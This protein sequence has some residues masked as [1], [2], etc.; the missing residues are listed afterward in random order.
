MDSH[1]NNPSAA[2]SGP[3]S[4]DMRDP[5]Q[6]AL[7][8]TT[9]I[10][11]GCSNGAEPKAEMPAKVRGPAVAGLF[12]PLNDK[13]LAENIDELLAE[14][15]AAD[16]KNLRALVA[17][18]A[19]YKYSGPVAASAYKQLAGRR[20]ETVV[21]MSPSHFARF[22]GAYV[23]AVD[24]YETPLGRMR[25]SPKAAQL[26]KT[27]PF[28]AD[29]RC[30]MQRPD[31]WRQS[32]KE[33]PPFGEEAPD[34]WEHSL[35][36]QLPFI[37]RMLGEV[38]LIPITFGN[39][40]GADVARG[41]APLVDRQT[42]LVASSDLSHYHAYDDASQRDR[43]CVQA[44]C[45][46]SAEW[47][48]QQEAC[49]MG[50]ILTVV[51]LARRNG[52]K[53]R[54]LDCRNSGDTTGDKSR[55]VVGYAAIAFYEPEAPPGAAPSAPATAAAEK[56]KP[57]YSPEQ[58]KRLLALARESLVAATARHRPPEA[59]AADMDDALLA[60]R[61]CFVTLTKEGK[62]RGCVGS[63]FPQE[64]LYQ[65]VLHRAR[66]AAVEDRRFTPVQP[67]EVS[68]IKIEISVLT[69][70][71]PIEYKTPNELLD[72]LRPHV[73]GVVLRVGRSQ[74]T[75]LPQ[76]WEQIPGKEEFLQHLSQKAGLESGDWRDPKAVVL[77][78]QVEA[79]E[80][81]QR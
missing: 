78:Y 23:P 48:R 13:K 33:L 15:K 43:S 36:V 68:Q 20:Y 66:S 26:A 57:R 67:D 54:L 79:F 73:D 58:R 28:T 51:E 25:L 60:H 62:L 1:E 50:P 59:D 74:S 29:R 61:G 5:R 9:T 70:P 75:F 18:H 4:E 27:E 52:W 72:K 38:A 31:F 55:G 37:Q 22:D 24:A 44:I 64:P 46:L 53:A 6:L 39:V 41:L 14:A 35:E 32:P 49:G 21:V 65:A 81:E 12:Y 56:D 3:G 19:G 7:V 2:A 69:L 71:R 80:E 17:P 77:S 30:Q 45:E 42:L 8:W 47:L 76:V 10:L 40:D 63:I 11:V 16:I 34:T